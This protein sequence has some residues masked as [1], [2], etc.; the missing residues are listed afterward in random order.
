MI[1]IIEDSM[2][3]GG[4]DM[5]EQ[6]VFQILHNM[7]KFTN[8]LI[9]KWNKIFSEDLGVSHI[10][11]LGYLHVNGKSRPSH[12][13]KALGLTPPTVTNLTNKL[14]KRDLAV[15]LYDEDDRRIILI[16]I[17]DEGIDIL[18]R[19]NEKGHNLRKEM[20]LKLTEEE[21]NQMLHIFEKLNA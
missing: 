19:A 17:T 2:K 18:N 20:F 4:K 14:V 5:Q 21:R 1:G 3:K 15:R 11:A 13:A 6:T 7:D 10:L 8:S 12:I 9:I 16:D